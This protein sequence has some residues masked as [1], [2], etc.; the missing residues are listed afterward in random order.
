[1]LHSGDYVPEL[2]YIGR[3]L[4]TLRPLETPLFN[5]GLLQARSP[6]NRLR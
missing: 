2:N 1:L 4:T 3:Y 6:S 5:V